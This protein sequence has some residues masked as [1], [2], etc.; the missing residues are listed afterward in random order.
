MEDCVITAA[1]A[2]LKRARQV[3]DAMLDDPQ[4]LA[5][6]EAVAQHCVDRLAAGNKL[7]FAGNGASA[8]DAQHLASDLVS[9]Y[10]FDR[11]GLAAISLSTDTSIL[12]AVGNDYG[13]ENAFS[14]QIEAIGRPGDV[15]IGISTSGRSPNVLKAFE[16]ARARGIA[17]VALT[18][19]K[20]DGLRSR[21]DHLLLV[22]SIE[23]PR[24][25]E[26]QMMLGHAL[27]GLIERSLFPSAT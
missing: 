27:C 24:V 20:G 13:F 26:A 17:S 14:R 6:L 22:P 16:A 1:A 9:R 15:F 21:V 18:G 7:M 23:A 5:T 12:T 2:E 8:G 4:L 10:A 25:Q 11:P 3:L 19:S